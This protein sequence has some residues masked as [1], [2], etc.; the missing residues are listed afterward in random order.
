MIAM[1]S[2][3][4]LKNLLS[5]AVVTG[6]PRSGVSVEDESPGDSARLHARR[7]R[8]LEVELNSRE[9][10]ETCENIDSPP[11]DDGECRLADVSANQGSRS[12]DSTGVADILQDV[13][14]GS[15]RL[16]GSKDSVSSTHSDISHDRTSHPMGG[17]TY[18]TER[19]LIGRND[20][21]R[22]EVSCGFVES[23][24]QSRSANNR[25]G[26]LRND[27]QLNPGL[28]PGGGGLVCAAPERVHAKAAHSAES[29]PTRLRRMQL[30]ASNRNVGY[31]PGKKTIPAAGAT[32]A[33]GSGASWEGF[34]GKEDGKVGGSIDELMD[35]SHLSKRMECL[36][37]NIIVDDQEH[38]E[39]IDFSKKYTE[40]QRQGANRRGAGGGVGGSEG[41]IGVNQRAVDNIQSLKNSQNIQSPSKLSYSN[42]RPPQIVSNQLSTNQL[43]RSSTS[44]QPIAT[45][46]RPLLLQKISQPQRT[47]TVNQSSNNAQLA[48]TNSVNIPMVN[49]A[50]RNNSRTVPNLNVFALQGG[51]VSSFSNSTHSKEAYASVGVVCD[52]GMNRLGGK[53]SS[54]GNITDVADT[55][56]D[57]PTNFSIRFAENE[58][59]ETDD[60]FNEQPIDYSMRYMEPSL[61]KSQ[62]SKN[63]PSM[64]S[65]GTRGS[66]SLKGGGGGK[67][68]AEGG[69]S[70]N[71]PIAESFY[72]DTMQ[73]FCT[74]GTPLNFLS[75]ATSMT[76]LSTKGQGQSNGLE[77][78]RAQVHTVA[79]TGSQ[80]ASSF[81]QTSNQKVDNSGYEKLGHSI[82]IALLFRLYCIIFV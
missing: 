44:Q 58:V 38:D 14:G 3:A 67:R 7:S 11:R 47:A 34:N 57:Q 31:S 76:D 61:P 18:R 50:G 36:H 16:S 59:E 46:V 53:N 79:R 60:D 62:L 17:E 5:G 37:M 32:V 77:R 54:V 52:A 43:V 49:A 33:S 35:F 70:M 63:P 39:P 21:R 64:S 55:S 25:I 19:D 51:T 81:F 23:G 2:A 1:G 42:I 9:L 78:G 75:T 10:S 80:E 41:I 12:Y 13:V 45:T 65:E 30:P 22:L 72:E 28:Y 40:P 4:A 82:S 26:R 27:T 20:G 74:E 73:T 68:R 29:S 24:D 69:A 8:S 15:T 66:D 6:S 71:R 56:A 48:V